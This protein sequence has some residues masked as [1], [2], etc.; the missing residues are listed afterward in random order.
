[1]TFVPGEFSVP[2]WRKWP[3]DQW[4]AFVTVDAY[5]SMAQLDGGT[6][7]TDLFNEVHKGK[8][9]SSLGKKTNEARRMVRSEIW[10]NVD[11]LSVQN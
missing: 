9:P 10:R 4:A 7:F 5:S 2:V 8:D 6:S 1:M 11:G 3:G